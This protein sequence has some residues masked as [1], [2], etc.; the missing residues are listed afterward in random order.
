MSYIKRDWDNTSNDVTKEDFKRIENGVEANDI[1]INVCSKNKVLNTPE[2]VNDPNLESGIY[3]VEGVPIQFTP[4]LTV[5]YFALIVNKHRYNVGYGTQVAIPYDSGAM[6]GVYY[7]VCSAGHWNPFSKL[8]ESKLAP[9]ALN[10]VVQTFVMP[11][12]CIIGNSLTINGDVGIPANTPSGTIVGTLPIGFRVP[13]NFHIYLNS[14][15]ANLP[16]ISRLWVTTDGNIAV[17]G[18]DAINTACTIEFNKTLIV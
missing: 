2:E 15:D 7:R 8:C 16:Y 1:K 4:T 3:S 18:C 5:P 10:G 6:N 9:I 14:Y 17:Y 13:Y 11:H 12:V